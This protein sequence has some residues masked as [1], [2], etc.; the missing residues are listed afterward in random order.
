MSRTVFAEPPVTLNRITWHGNGWMDV[1]FAESMSLSMNFFLPIFHQIIGSRCQHCRDTSFSS[2]TDPTCPNKIGDILKKIDP[3]V[4]K[5]T[6]LTI[7]FGKRMA[8]FIR[9]LVREG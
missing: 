7:L 1:A 6:K 4:Q 9:L 2:P 8:D 5:L 3:T